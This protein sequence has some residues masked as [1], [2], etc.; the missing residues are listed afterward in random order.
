ML[1]MSQGR[2]DESVELIEQILA[3]NP[4]RAV[5]HQLLGRV[6]V[7]R[8]QAQA[9]LEEL[10]REPDEF[11]KRYGIN[12]ALFAAGRQ[13]EADAI[14]QQLIDGV[15]GESAYFQV[16]ESMAFRGRLDEAFDW[17]ELAYEHRD[18]GIVEMM[19]SP[20]LRPLHTD[21][22]WPALLDKLGLR[23]STG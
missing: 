17:L 18:N 7:L 8:G 15:E 9:A 6:H 21:A 3:L 4:K 22:R 23:V 11:W 2:L 13:D 10:D 5:A 16:A 14:L 19:T 12:L 1:L 20:F